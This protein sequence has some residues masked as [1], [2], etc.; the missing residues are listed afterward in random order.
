MLFL[1][2]YMR[3]GKCP[4]S[5]GASNEGLYSQDWS[6]HFRQL[7]DAVVSVPG[8]YLSARIGICYPEV[9][10]STR[11][12]ARLF[13]LCLFSSRLLFLRLFID[14]REL[15]NF[16]NIQTM[17]KTAVTMDTISHGQ[18]IVPGSADGSFVVQCKDSNA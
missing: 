8:P 1:A 2:A 11:A 18:T 9:A 5:A 17:T 16:V 14:F 7:S 10:R 15:C 6:D 12:S 4:R 13:F 3:G